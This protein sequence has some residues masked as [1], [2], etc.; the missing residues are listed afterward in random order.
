MIDVLTIGQYL[1]P[2]RQHLP[3][4]KY[5][6][7]AEFVALRRIGLEMGFRHVQSGPLVRSSLPRRRAGARRRDGRR[8]LTGRC[9]TTSNPRR[10]HGDHAS[11]TSSRPRE[12]CT[13]ED[14]TWLPGPTSPPIAFHL[15]HTGRW[16]DRWAEAI[17]GASRSAGIREAI[18]RPRGSFPAGARARATPAWS[19]PMTR[20]PTSPSRA[21][22]QLATYL[23]GA[24][25]DLEQA[26]GAL[27]DDTILAPADDLLGKQAPARRL[28][29]PAPRHTSAATSA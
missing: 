20:P 9:A 13:D 11:A 27:D 18:W 2:S 6:T 21:A 8:G 10:P 15:W 24:F 26:V 17:S 16:A 19:C 28:A 1:R 7:P 14:L 3:L 5:Y 12:A 4:H 23:R 22:T 25:N 29:D